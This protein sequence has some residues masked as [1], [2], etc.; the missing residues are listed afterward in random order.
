MSST[1]PAKK[2]HWILFIGIIVITIFI[3]LY[4]WYWPTVHIALQTTDMQLTLADTSAHL[5]Q[6]LSDR[7]AIP[8]EGMLFMFPT[9]GQHGMVMR[10]MKFPLDI[11]WVKTD[12]TTVETCGLNTFNLRKLLVPVYYGCIGK[13]VD[14][15]PKLPPEST[16]QTGNDEV[17]YWP[18]GPANLAVEL[19]AGTITSLNLKVGGSVKVY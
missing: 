18:R 3:K 9:Y 14:L 2:I 1:Q 17:V 19:P 12:T 15:A 5:I 10:R 8:N 11:V 6:G 4:S 7:T 13:I 16:E